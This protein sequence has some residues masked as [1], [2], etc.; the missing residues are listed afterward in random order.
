MREVSELSPQT[1]WAQSAAVALP[2]KTRMTGFLT[3]SRPRTLCDDLGVLLPPFDTTS[4]RASPIVEAISSCGAD[5]C[6]VQ[7]V[8]L[9]LPI[10]ASDLFDPSDV[11]YLGNVTVVTPRTPVHGAARLDLLVGLLLPHPLLHELQLPPSELE[12]DVRLVRREAA[13]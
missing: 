5:K 4:A 12:G 8:K 9:L 1:L 11:V 10:A 13:Y 2:A 3:C 7:T 6:D